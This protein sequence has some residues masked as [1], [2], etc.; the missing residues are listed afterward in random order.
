M[1]YFNK[2]ETPK[3]IMLAMCDEDLMGRLLREGKVEINLR[4]YGGF[5][6]GD[7]I[8][9]EEA[10]RRINGRVYSA[11]VVGNKSVGVLVKKGIIKDGEAKT[12]DG[13]MYVHLF[14]VDK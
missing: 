12:V 7:L 13:I 5:Y 2:F 8:S 3:G 14:K 9:E 10:A 6:K 1:I 4:D 11:N